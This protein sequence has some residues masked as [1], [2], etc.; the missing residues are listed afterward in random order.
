MLVHKGVPPYHKGGQ[1]VEL[2]PGE[3]VVK[4]VASE[5]SDFATLAKEHGP[6]I[7][8][9]L[10]SHQQAVKDKMLKLAEKPHYG[11]SLVE[12]LEHEKKTT[13]QF[14]AKHPEAKV[15]KVPKPRSKTK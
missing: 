15:V 12:A 14:I 13:K 1:V 4:D 8:K 6:S 10:D 11:R 5:Y 7:D 9:I 3:R 2:E